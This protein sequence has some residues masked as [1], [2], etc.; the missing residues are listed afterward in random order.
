VVLREEPVDVAVLEE[1]GVARVVIGHR[2]KSHRGI[3]AILRRLEQGARL[4]RRRRELAECSGA[5]EA[6]PREQRP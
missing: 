4:Q 1:V 6:A 5:A 2:R 3:A